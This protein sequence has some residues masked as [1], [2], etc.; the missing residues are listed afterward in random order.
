MPGLLSELTQITKLNGNR[1]TVENGGSSL[2]SAKRARPSSG[3]DGADGAGG[4][5][6]ADGADGADGNKNRHLTPGS[7]DS[8]RLKANIGY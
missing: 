5:G 2:E 1:M 3:A 6:G 8:K 7:L 4:A